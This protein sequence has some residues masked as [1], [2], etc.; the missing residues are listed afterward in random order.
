MEIVFG[1][2]LLLVAWHSIVSLWD[3]LNMD[4]NGDCIFLKNKTRRRYFIRNLQFGFPST[5]SIDNYSNYDK[6][7]P[8]YTSGYSN[9]YLLVGLGW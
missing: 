1:I 3:I 4:K 6:D 7:N 8:R 5:Y 9:G 2:L